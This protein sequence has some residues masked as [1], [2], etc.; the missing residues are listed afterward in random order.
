MPVGGSI[1][2]GNVIW[3][4]LATWTTHAM[5]AGSLDTPELTASKTTRTTIIQEEDHHQSQQAGQGGRT[6]G[7]TESES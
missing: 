3:E 7:K 2:M 6:N 1:S 5:S 4:L